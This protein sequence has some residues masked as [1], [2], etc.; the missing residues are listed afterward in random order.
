MNSPPD[1]TR[2]ENP[3]INQPIYHNGAPLEDAQVIAIWLHDAHSTASAI[4]QLARMLPHQQIAHLAPQ[5][6]SGIWLPYNTLAP[7]KSNQPYTD[8]ALE[9]ITRLL[10]RVQQ[11]RKTALPPIL[12]GGF[13]Q[14]ASLVC[15]YAL[16]FT[17]ACQGLILL[18]G[19][20]MGSEEEIHRH[21]TSLEGLRTF[22]GFGE[23]DFHTPLH[24]MRTTSHILQHLGAQVTMRTYPHMGHIINTDEVQ[25][26]RHLLR[27]LLP[28]MTIAS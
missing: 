1:T 3:H 8:F 10:K 5:A 23:S 11:K 20:I 16:R 17:G 7:L 13:G 19:G 21:A 27:S 28:P 24:R 2:T 9:V 14:G 12:L 6:E 22:I 15:E 4:L 25:H 26:C 18:S